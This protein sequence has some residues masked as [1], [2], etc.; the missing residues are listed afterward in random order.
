M[1]PS[2]RAGETC[3]ARPHRAAAA[4]RWD[5]LV[6]AVF[7]AA[8]SSAGAGRPSFW[9]DEAATI[10]AATR[11]MPELWRMLGNVDAVH[12]LYYLLM[13]IWLSVVPATEFWV[14]VPSCL[15]IGAAAAGT[16]VLARLYTSRTVAVTAGIV[17]A[18][19][20]RVTWAGIEARP[21][22]LSTAC[23]VWV[24]VLLVVALRRRRNGWWLGYAVA[25]MAVTVL[26]L[27]TWLIVL[28][29]AVVVVL[30]EQR[31]ATGRRWVIAVAAA[32][33]VLAP[34]VLFS[35]TQ[36]DQIRWISPLNLDKLREIGFEQYFDH[37]LLFAV[38]VAVILILTLALR[39]LALLDRS[40]RDLAVIAIAWLVLPTTVLVLYSA[41]AEPVYYPRYL[42]FT[43]PAA[44]LLIAISI[45]ALVRTR[46]KITA[47]LAALAVAATPNFVFTQ[48]GPYGKEGMDYSRIADLLTAKAAPGDCIVLDNTI[49][50]RPGLIRPITAARPAAFEKLVDPGRGARAADRNALWDEPIAI[51]SVIDAVQRCT[52]IWTVSDRDS[53]L[54]S[55]DAGLSID[56]GPRMREAPA[57]RV[58][59]S[60]GFQI[61]ERW[62]FNF[63]QVT[64]STR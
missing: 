35:N 26:N 7:A 62:Q 6:I 61:A 57:F 38:G 36:V 46:N 42:C 21:Y 27:F 9:W 52:V 3:A 32:T 8:L 39:R 17:F 28:P 58:Q 34:F 15:A 10:S 49:R 60:L 33:I 14:R 45:V 63:A 18:I 41:V 51:W 37:S 19:L 54:P 2:L 44:A 4:R 47:V 64:R 23:A 12:G 22:A 1:Q 13:H 29:H 11:S 43:T 30:T 20:P 5:P 24:T 56:P 31:R 55:Y 59:E 48:R 53:A 40:D 25:V 16:V 50:W